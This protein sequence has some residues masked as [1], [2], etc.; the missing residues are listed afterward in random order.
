LPGL[1]ALNALFRA[2][3]LDEAKR[4]VAG[5]TES[6]GQRFAQD[7]AAAV[8]LPAVGE[9]LT[10]AILDEEEVQAALR[11]VYRYP[12]DHD[13]ELGKPPPLKRWL[14]CDPRDHIFEID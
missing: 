3:C 13:E 6:I 5:H 2:R 1:A 10:D 4:T 8:T 9:E 11:R 7:R 12:Q 14:R